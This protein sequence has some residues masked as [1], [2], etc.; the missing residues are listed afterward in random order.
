[1]RDLEQALPP[2]RCASHVLYDK[3]SGAGALGVPARAPYPR[4][5]EAEGTPVSLLG[6]PRGASRG[7][8]PARGPPPMTDS[9]QLRRRQIGCNPTSTGP[10]DKATDLQGLC[11]CRNPDACQLPALCAQRDISNIP[12]SGLSQ[13]GYHDGL[14]SLKRNVR[15]GAIRLLHQGNLHIKQTITRLP[16]GGAPLFAPIEGRHSY[17]I[18]LPQRH[19]T[20]VRSRRSDRKMAR[21]RQATLP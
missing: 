18:D 15:R 3:A 16:R 21:A 14:A 5:V 10:N 11:C 4:R 20:N 17:G 19:S 9:P 7:P 1:M 2:P 8:I 12:S 6:C 13:R